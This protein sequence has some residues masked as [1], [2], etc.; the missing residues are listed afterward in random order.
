MENGDDDNGLIG[1]KIKD[2]IGK[3]PENSLPDIFVDYWI[4]FRVPENQLDAPIDASHELR[5]ETWFALL[6]PK[7]CLL[8]FNFGR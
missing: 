5:A 1:D 4:N 6:I 3:A 7:E 2:G 8:Q